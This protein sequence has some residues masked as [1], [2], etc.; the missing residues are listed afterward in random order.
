MRKFTI[1]FLLCALLVSCGSEELH[2]LPDETAAETEAENYPYTE[3]SDRPISGAP[4]TSLPWNLQYADGYLCIASFGG[5]GIPS[6]ENSG[7]MYT[8][9]RINPATGNI[10]D[11]CPDPLCA[12]NSADCPFYGLDSMPVGFADNKIFYRR[13]WITHAD[14]ETGR[15]DYYSADVVF[16]TKTGKVTELKNLNGEGGGI[17]SYL[18]TDTHRYWFDWTW[19]E[20]ST[21][22]GQ[23]VMYRAAYDRLIPETVAE[24][25]YEDA[26]FVGYA[27][28]TLYFTDGRM[29][30]STDERYEN[31]RDIAE[32]PLTYG[33]HWFGGDSVYYADAAS[34]IFR[35]L[36][37]TGEITDM[38]FSAG[39]LV[40]TD[41]WIYYTSPEAVSLGKNRVYGMLGDEVTVTGEHIYRCAHDGTG[42]ET[43][44]SFDGGLY[45]TRFRSFTAVGNY[46]WGTYHRW[47]DADGDGIYRDGDH[48]E[49]SD[50]GHVLRIDVTTGEILELSTAEM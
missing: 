12:H 40:I 10:T 13:R 33:R 2:Y 45:S 48:Y 36:L 7:L 8:L 38:G 46:L 11:V 41:S 35:I 29:L 9:R 1:L 21:E 26:G 50:D 31:R 28:G 25:S 6:E 4:V 49:S 32:A 30:Y 34:R 42:T 16:D 3:N 14:G 22:S 44:F 24:V 17:N 23:Y 47:D 5:M 37:E 27:D 19:D 39:E 15:V 18:Y 43:V 20:N